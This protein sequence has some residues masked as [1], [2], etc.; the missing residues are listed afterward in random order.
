MNTLALKSYAKVN[1][2][3][4][5]KNQREDGYHSL[6]T[7]FQEL[8]LHD[9]ISL[10]KISYGWEI[11]VNKAGVPADENNTCIKAYLELKKEC[12]KIGGISIKIDKNIPSGGG[13][14]GGSGNA[15]AV[16]KGINQIYD[17]N[18]SDKELE[19]ISTRVGADVP[20]FIKG[21]TQIGDGMGDI[22]TLVENPVRGYYLL[23]LPEI[24]ISTGW[25][26]K[27]MKKYL[28]E[29]ID[30]PNFAH[31]LERKNLEQTIFDNDFERIVIPTYP[32][33]GEIKDG[34]KKAGA[35][36][37]SLS[38]SGSTVFGIFNDEAEAKKAE[39][40]FREQYHT[41]LTKPTNI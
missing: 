34:L 39:F 20:F 6:H 2:G 40:K 26:Y 13:L 33:I 15:A 4:Q 14:G 22:L 37:A 36:Y 12:P 41:Y 9:N 8:N 29:E 31:F 16:L 35:S 18:L 24:F 17:L 5:I 1:I 11:S 3:L 23:V 30:R 19:K 10:S 28:D 27:S 21:G 38:G 25:A 7:V 32:E